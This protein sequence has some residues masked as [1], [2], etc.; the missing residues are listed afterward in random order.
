MKLFIFGILLLQGWYHGGH[1]EGVKFINIEEEQEIHQAEIDETCDCDGQR[2]KNADLTALREKKI[3][4][5]TLS[6]SLPNNKIL[7]QESYTV[8]ENI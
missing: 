8:E 7:A 3:L 6:L 5:K 2:R 4:K 1:D